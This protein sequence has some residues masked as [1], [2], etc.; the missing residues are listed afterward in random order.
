MEG[1]HNKLA[2]VRRWMALD[3]ALA[4]GGLLVSSFAGTEGVNRATVRRDLEALRQL[5]Q[6]I[7]FGAWDG[8]VREHRYRYGK[9]TVPLFS[10]NLKKR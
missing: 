2:V 3:S 4:R 6:R 1:K 10:R 7:E 5:G 8:E 9:G